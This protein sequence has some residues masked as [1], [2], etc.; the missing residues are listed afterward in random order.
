MEGMIHCAVH[1]QEPAEYMCPACENRPL[2]ELC[3]QNHEIGAMHTSENFK[4][5]G[6]ALMHQYIQSASGTLAKELANR[7]MKVVKE[8]EDG[9][10]QEIK[11]FES[12]F[13]NS[14]V[15]CYNMQKL[16]SERR[17][18][19]LYRYAKS[20][21]ASGTKSK[22]A[23]GELNKRL[24]EVLDTTS[25][26]LKK[27][28]NDIAAVIQYKPV[29]SAYHNK[30]EVFV[31][32]GKP[33]GDEDKIVSALKTADMS[34]THL[35]AVYIKP[36]IKIGDRVASELASRLQTHP[37][38]ALY[39]AGCDISD[40]GA[41]KL[42]QAAFR[43]KSLSAFCV[44]STAMS[45]KGAAAVAEAARNSHSLTALYL[46]SREIS[47][48]G[49]KA[50]A[51]AVKSCPLSVFYLAGA[52]ISDSGA[53]AVAEALKDCPMST[54]CLAG[55]EISDAEA[56]SVAGTMAEGP[57]SAFYL[58]SSKISD[59]GALAVAKALSSG[60]CAN[61]LSAFCL[62]SAGISEPGAKKVADAVRGCLLISSLYL[63]SQPIS[64]E[65]MA[66]ILDGLAGVSTIR[67]VNLCIGKISKE[68][69]DGCL[70]RLKK[71]GIAAQLK[72]RFR[73][74]IKDA[75]NAYGEF[76]A[77]W[78]ARLAEFRIVPHINY[79]FIEDVILGAPK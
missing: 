3:K 66:Y 27:V 61:T 1:P 37:V 53:R 40:V 28:L 54:F 60:G 11:T 5:V 77:E 78:G 59:S 4:E 62:V 36:F 55:S 45:D 48:S 16:D 39:L 69:M 23:M 14:D 46:D 70:D 29:F 30:D 65:A 21:S 19:E 79:T 68:Q 17:Y 12:N 56:E 24:L 26:G 9:L 44:S 25:A 31:L 6:L 13:V 49:A 10:L 47:D 76:A 71:S 33:C 73:C 50:V 64:G 63:D 51:E 2:C 38:S 8:F 74:D 52:S 15:Q 7:L 20:L 18:A 72:L 75:K 34:S 35:K 57:L 58:G 43:S 41:K 42:A 67:S 22:A 32:E